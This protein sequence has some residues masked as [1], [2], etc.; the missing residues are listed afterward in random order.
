LLPYFET[1]QPGTEGMLVETSGVCAGKPE[2][3]PD[4]IVELA[5]VLW[6]PVFTLAPVDAS[7]LRRTLRRHRSDSVFHTGPPRH[8]LFA[9]FLV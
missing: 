1:A 9:V 6:T 3:L 7:V 5:P 4:R 8:K 2:A